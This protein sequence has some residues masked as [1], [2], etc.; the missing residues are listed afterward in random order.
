[1]LFMVTVAPAHYSLVLREQL[2]AMAVQEI[3]YWRAE[4]RYLEVSVVSALK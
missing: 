3:V 1:M 4:V 2:Q